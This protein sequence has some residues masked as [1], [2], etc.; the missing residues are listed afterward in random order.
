MLVW[1]HSYSRQN[2]LI[3]YLVKIT[4]LL[5]MRFNHPITNALYLQKLR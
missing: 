4:I 1:W 3:N 5:L 2:N